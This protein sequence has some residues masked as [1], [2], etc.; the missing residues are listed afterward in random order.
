MSEAVL[1]NEAS[2][3]KSTAGRSKSEESS[4]IGVVDTLRIIAGLLLINCVASYFVTGDSVTWNYRPWWIRPKV[5]AARLVSS[6]AYPMN[7]VTNHLFRDP[8]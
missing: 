8:Q 5:L 4:G 2:K 3:A 7:R 1:N 6:Q